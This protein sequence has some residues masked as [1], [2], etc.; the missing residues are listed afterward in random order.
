[1]LHHLIIIIII[2][3]LFPL[4]RLSCDSIQFF[5]LLVFKL[6]GDNFIYLRFEIIIFLQ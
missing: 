1:M 3:L 2:T 6:T 5:I 4:I